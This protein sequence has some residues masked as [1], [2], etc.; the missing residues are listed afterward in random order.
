MIKTK[1]DFPI[2]QFSFEVSLNRRYF[3]N[4]MARILFFGELA[5]IAGVRELNLVVS[6][7]EE[8]KT[9]IIDMF[10]AMKLK[11]FSVAVNRSIVNIDD[12]PISVGDEIALMPPFSGG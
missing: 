2:W 9:K 11:T 6:D 7:T 10:P 4:A 12:L 3:A 5:E 1:N 8:L